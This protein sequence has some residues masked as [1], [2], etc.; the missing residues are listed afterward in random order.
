MSGNIIVSR[1]AGVATITINSEAKRNAMSQAMWIAMGDALEQLST[2]T[3]LRCIVLR[4]AG[5][6]AF[7]SGADIDEFETIRATKAQGIAFGK[8]GHRAMHAV[9][10]CPIPTVAA[11]R[12]V[13][14]G[15]GLELAAGCDVRLTS[16][17][18]RFGVPIGKL[19]AVLAYPE[20]ANLIR[21]AGPVTALE[22]VLE[23]RVIDAAEAYVKGIVSRVVTVAGFDEE[24]KKTVNRI[25]AGAPLSARWHKKFT[26]RLRR[27]EPLTE[28][29]LD[30]G[31][32]CFDTSDFVEGY[33]AFITKRTPVFS[34]K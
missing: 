30:E 13:C 26:A 7:G 1:E 29:E 12:G 34:G 11:I 10:D 24:L 25:V 9:R 31:Y 22:L 19:G 20:L 5:T 15:G 4:G 6:T 17:D 21:V 23:G 28:A 8:H 18:G 3:D 33:Q 32:A 16:D 2:E 14:V 27:P